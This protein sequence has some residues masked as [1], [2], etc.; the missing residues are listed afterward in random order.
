MLINGVSAPT[1]RSACNVGRSTARARPSR[2]RDTSTP[3]RMGWAVPG[4]HVGCASVAAAG[5]QPRRCAADRSPVP[6]VPARPPAT[7]DR[8]PRRPRSTARIAPD[9]W[10]RRAGSDRARAAPPHGSPLPRHRPGSGCAVHSHAP[11][12]SST[13]SALSAAVTCAW[14]RASPA[15]GTG[16]HVTEAAERAIVMDRSNS[17]LG[18]ARDREV[19]RS[20]ARGEVGDAHHDLRPRLPMAFDSTS[21]AV[22]RDVRRPERTP[23]GR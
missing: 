4:R 7:S 3:S 9:R 12:S 14:K 5:A 8:T 2:P 1:P 22:T 23:N 20:V 16:Q 18:P 19:H 6:A 17:A 21:N 15:E 13:S 11:A 10:P